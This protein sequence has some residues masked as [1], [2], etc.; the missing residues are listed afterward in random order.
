MDSCAPFLLFSSLRVVGDMNGRPFISPLRVPLMTT[1]PT[2]FSRLSEQQPA[3]IRPTSIEV[4]WSVTAGLGVKVLRMKMTATNGGHKY[5]CHHNSFNKVP[6][7]QNKR[8]ISKN[9]NCPATITIKVMLDTKII[10]KRDE[11]AMV[12]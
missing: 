6:S 12:S 1:R 2:A 10:R 9:S 8:G 7:S 5:V 3:E 11:Y 4:A